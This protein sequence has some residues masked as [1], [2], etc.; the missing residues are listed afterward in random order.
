MIKYNSF[1]LSNVSPDVVRFGD[2]NIYSDEDDRYA[3]QL[4]IVSIIRHPKYSF[5]ARY[6]DIALM[7]LE[8]NVS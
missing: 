2:L 6:Y 4:T 3:Q 1:F 7:K 8:H 5:S